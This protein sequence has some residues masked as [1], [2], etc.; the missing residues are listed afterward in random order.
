MV[1]A[2]LLSVV[3]VSRFTT[4]LDNV[5]DDTQY[6]NVVTEWQSWNDDGT[7]PIRVLVYSI[8]MILSITGL[9]HIRKANDVVINFCTN[10]SIVTAGLYLLSM[11]TSGIFIGRLPI[12]ASLYSNG[13]LLPWEIEHMYNSG[14]SKYM[15]FAAISGYALLYLYQIHFQWHII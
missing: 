5:L 3:F 6:T 7:N 13:I 2:I 1:A 12:Y 14:S 15:K 8:P 11:V 4:W 10:M 9:R